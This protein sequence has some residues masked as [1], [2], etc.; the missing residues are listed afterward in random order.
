MT[1]NQTTP[2]STQFDYL[3]NAFEQ[4][5]QS[6]KP[7]EHGYANKR[8]AL[9]DYVRKLEGNTP[10]S[11]LT[12]EQIIKAFEGGLMP[13]YRFK[14]F[15]KDQELV[16]IVRALLSAQSL[17]EQS[18]NEEDRKDA[19]IQDVISLIANLAAVVRVQ[20]GNLHDDINSLLSHADKAIE[21]LEAMQGE[22][23]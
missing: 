10:A 2:A 8:K 20:N 18:G 13:G 1:P 4:A 15:F 12:D 5:S 16:S 14:Y 11:V 3:L 21:S 7:A 9:L 17:K 6:D 19:D 23:K 22:N